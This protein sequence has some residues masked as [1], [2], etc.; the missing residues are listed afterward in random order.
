M[1]QLERIKNSKKLFDMTL[2]FKGQTNLTFFFFISKLVWGSYIADNVN[3]NQN[4]DH[5][6]IVYENMINL[7][8]NQICRMKYLHHV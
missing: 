7:S 3:I 5:F 6:K 4:V 2:A 8:R 1:L